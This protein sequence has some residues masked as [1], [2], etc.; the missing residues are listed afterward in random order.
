MDTIQQVVAYLKRNRVPRQ[1]APWK[2]YKNKGWLWG[3]RLTFRAPDGRLA[4]LSTQGKPDS[5]DEFLRDWQEHG[6][7]MAKGPWG[8]HPATARDHITF[9]MPGKQP[10]KHYPGLFFRWIPSKK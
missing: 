3:E 2:E 7:T 5:I 6:A 8:V 1:Q 10:N 4:E 9:P